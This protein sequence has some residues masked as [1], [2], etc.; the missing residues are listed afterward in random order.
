MNVA[1]H[2]NE[3]SWQEKHHWYLM[4]KKT[5]E[6]NDQDTQEVSFNKQDRAPSG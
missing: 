1:V 6:T 2:V 3:E 4:K 5:A